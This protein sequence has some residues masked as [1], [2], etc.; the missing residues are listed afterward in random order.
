M[1]KGPEALR[2]ILG[3]LFAAKGWGRRQERLQL[4]E[5]WTESA[6]PQTAKHT[7]I[8]SFRHAWTVD[9]KGCVNYKK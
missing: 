4:E 8:G 6:G 5:A 2:D 3:R 9:R 1:D 7:Q